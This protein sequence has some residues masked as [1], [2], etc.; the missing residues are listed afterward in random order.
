MGKKQ[1]GIDKE[2]KKVSGFDLSDMEIYD[3]PKTGFYEIASTSN[4]FSRTYY[5]KE[6]SIMIPKSADLSI[7]HILNME[8]VL[9]KFSDLAVKINSCYNT[10]V[11]EGVLLHGIQGSGKTTTMLGLASLFASKFESCM[12]ILIKK[13]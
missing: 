10:P 5:F 4:G 8:E 7:K 1:F 12:I 6:K 3:K 2:T 11:K 13:S 9:T